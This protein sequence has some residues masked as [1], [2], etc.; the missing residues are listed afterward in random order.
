MA[1]PVEELIFDFIEQAIAAAPEG[2]VLHG[3]ELHDTLFKKIEKSEGVR[4]GDAESEFSP[5][6]ANELQEYDALVT[7]VCFAKIEGANKLDRS[8]ARNKAF[9]ISLAVAK[10]FFDDH[11]MGGR[12][13]DTKLLPAVRGWDAPSSQPYAVVNMP[14][15]VNPSGATNF[16]RRRVY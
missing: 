15:V 5:N 4:I 16:E 13:C 8:A 6:E 9:Q 12:V 11:T 10:L 3:L 7:L 14:V 1:E 2:Q